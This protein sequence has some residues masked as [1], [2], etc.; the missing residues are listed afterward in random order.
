MLGKWGRAIEAGEWADGDI[1][2]CGILPPLWN[3]LVRVSMNVNKM[4]QPTRQA[5][6]A[7]R[8]RL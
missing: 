3:E 1:T 5:G 8:R 7:A 4:A 2:R 6:R